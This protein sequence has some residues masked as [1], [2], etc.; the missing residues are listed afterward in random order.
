MFELFY[1]DDYLTKL[2][3]R[4]VII[5]SDSEWGNPVKAIEKPNGHIWFVSNFMSLNYLRDSDPYKPKNIRNVIIPHG[6]MNT[7][8]HWI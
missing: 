6:L 5:R 1:T 2:E 8:Q 3:D 4:G 7:L